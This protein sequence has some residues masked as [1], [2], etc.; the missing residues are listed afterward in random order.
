MKGEV[1]V[2]V[3]RPLL[4]TADVRDAPQLPHWRL[5]TIDG[6]WSNWE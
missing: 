3:W 2:L 4:C 6:D 5:G 1:C